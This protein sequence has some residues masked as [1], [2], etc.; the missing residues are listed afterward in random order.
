MNIQY[1]AGTTGHPSCR[2]ASGVYSHH[3]DPD[4]LNHAIKLRSVSLRAIHR[5]H[6][7]RAAGTYQA[8]GHDGV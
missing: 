5:G 7:D 4:D 1:H 2:S 3:A 8:E 6:A